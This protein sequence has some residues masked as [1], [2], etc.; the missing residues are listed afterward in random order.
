MLRAFLLVCY[1][2]ALVSAVMAARS[3]AAHKSGGAFMW[4]A[5]ILPLVSV[6]VQYVVWGSRSPWKLI[7]GTHVQEADTEVTRA[8]WAH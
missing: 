8:P 7:K 3:L 6:G 1:A 4:I 5:I 2:G